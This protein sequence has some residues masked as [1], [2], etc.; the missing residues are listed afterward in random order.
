M[1]VARYQGISSN[2]D[3]ALIELLEQVQWKLYDGPAGA[4]TSQRASEVFRLKGSMSYAINSLT[5]RIS[6]MARI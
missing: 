5:V 2:E 6:L 3:A 1:D 4:G